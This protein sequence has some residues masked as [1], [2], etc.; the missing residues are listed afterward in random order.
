MLANQNSRYN[1][2]ELGIKHFAH[3][4]LGLMRNEFL[5]KMKARYY[6]ILLYFPADIFYG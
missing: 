2:T 5:L 6:T 1:R 4:E 3:K